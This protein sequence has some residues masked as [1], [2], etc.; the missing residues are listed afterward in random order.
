MSE[1]WGPLPPEP[2]ACDADCADTH[3]V[4]CLKKAIAA[5]QQLLP[6]AHQNPH[7]TAPGTIISATRPMDCTVVTSIV[8][9]S[10]VTLVDIISTRMMGQY[11]FLSTVF[12][13]FRRH[14][15]SVDVVATSEVRP[16]LLA[17]AGLQGAAGLG[18]AGSGHDGVSLVAASGRRYRLLKHT[19][20]AAA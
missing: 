5:D 18:A 8:L 17:S 12:D 20:F 9:K 14:K 6:P 15:I 7:S 13:A 11:G 2:A 4:T 16:V 19:C 3:L 1:L 10:N